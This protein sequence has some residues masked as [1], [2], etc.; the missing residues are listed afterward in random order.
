MSNDHHH[1]TTPNNPNPCPQ[2]EEWKNKGNSYFKSKKFKQAS[3]CYQKAIELEPHHAIYHCN[4]SA[5]WIGLQNYHGAIESAERA[6][7]L[8]PLYDKAYVRWIQSLVEL[9]K[10]DKALQVLIR[11]Y[12][13]FKSH[14]KLTIELEKVMEQ[15][16]LDVKKALIKKHDR[17]KK[18]SVLLQ[19]GKP[20]AAIPG[21]N[22]SEYIANAALF[23]K[24]YPYA[25]S[26]S[27]IPDP[28][29]ILTTEHVM[30]LTQAFELEKPKI[31]HFSAAKKI[32]NKLM[33]PSNRE[34]TITGGNFRQAG[35]C[36]DD[37]YI[38]DRVTW[39]L[40]TFPAPQHVDAIAC[41]KYTTE[42]TASIRPYSC[43]IY[44][45]T[46]G[47]TI[48][49]CYASSMS[50][51]SDSKCLP[52]K[53]PKFS[54]A[55]E[56]ISS[57]CDLIV[58]TFDASHGQAFLPEQ[59]VIS[60]TDYMKSVTEAMVNYII[61]QHLPAFPCV[62]QASRDE[63]P[64]SIQQ[65]VHDFRSI[66][67]IHAGHIP[68]PYVAQKGIR[69]MCVERGQNFTHE[70]GRSLF[71]ALADLAELRPWRI[72]STDFAI[73]VTIRHSKFFENKPFNTPNLPYLLEKRGIGIEGLDFMD[74]KNERIICVMGHT[75]PNSSGFSIL[76]DL[77]SF[78]TFI[79]MPHAIDACPSVQY[80][81]KDLIAH[82]DLDDIK[83][84]DW[85]I[86]KG[87]SRE[88]YPMI[89]TILKNFFWTQDASKIQRC[90]LRE[91]KWIEA[92]VR[93]LCAFIRKRCAHG[94]PVVNSPFEIVIDTHDGEA[95]VKIL[96]K[97]EYFPNRTA[98]KT[99]KKYQSA[100]DEIGRQFDAMVQEKQRQMREEEKKFNEKLD[101]T[102]SATTSSTKKSS[103][104]QE[105][106]TTT[107]TEKK[108]CACCGAKKSATTK[109][110]VCGACKSVLYCSRE[111]QQKD[112]PQHKQVCKK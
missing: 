36:V 33:N 8:D 65:T 110:F 5:A 88:F 29:R 92:A 64:L 62:V 68:H 38:K 55:L 25:T 106:P 3:E 81:P 1:S 13:T 78:L 51:W 7:Q 69:E 53:H 96:V 91:L 11:F 20:V 95:T 84:Y 34:N 26:R 85:P 71:G 52:V 17:V 47:Y 43:Q 100:L 89:A 35:G 15:K 40:V 79:P 82:D 80:T 90:D 102:S 104:K 44:E 12:E 2:A 19:Q 49:P 70:F 74:G 24:L 58:T 105:P 67:P 73:Y 99:Q 83:A 23:R 97:R 18:F 54:Y 37:K 21:S 56:I 77:E 112:W 93:G 72:F 86:Y 76:N 9:M 45:D 28:K 87:D 30:E 101:A 103:Q 108:C 60:C 22:L 14:N 39:Y 66:M 61:L 107:T 109:L 4:L 6:A 111:C 57:L 10:G 48:K 75:D 98:E 46:P 27:K 16:A 32:L 63:L 31:K 94:H 41:E 42:K 50:R 59:L